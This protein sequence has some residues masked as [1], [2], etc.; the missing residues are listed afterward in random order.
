MGEKWKL[1]KIVRHI[2][3]AD[4]KLVKDVP[5]WTHKNF[6]VLV[7]V[8]WYLLSVNLQNTFDFNLTYA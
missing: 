7:V 2:I 3:I 1:V 6:C 8:V 4:K 5:C